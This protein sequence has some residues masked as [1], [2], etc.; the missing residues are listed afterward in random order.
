MAHSRTK[1]LRLLAMLA[2]A[3]VVFAACGEEEAEPPRAEQ[4]TEPALTTV[5][6]GVLTVGSDIPFPPFEFRRGGELTGFDIELA[7]EIARRLNLT[8]EFVDT[9][10]DTIFTQLQAGRWDMVA[11]ATTVTPEREEQVDFSIPYYRAQQALTV[12]T[13]ETPNIQ[14]SDDL[15]RGDVVAVQRGTT[16]ESYVRENFRPRGVEVRSFPEAPA[17]YIALEAGDVTAV[18]LDEPSAAEEVKTRPSLEVVETIDTDEE[19]GFGINPQNKALLRE[20]NRVLQQMIDDGTYTRIYEKWFPDA[21]AG[22]IARPAAASPSPS[23]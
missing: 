2:A 17:T 20:V 4:P 12:N 14:S 3:L 10:F 11:S 7:E 18:L 15:G 16:G 9:D 19:Y 8:A 23:P 1:G 5:K 6:E 13:E 21:P 22:N